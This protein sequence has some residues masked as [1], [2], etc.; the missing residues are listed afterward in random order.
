MS[1]DWNSRGI[2]QTCGGL[3]V[4]PL[5]V[6]SLVKVWVWFRLVIPETFSSFFKWV[7]MN[8]LPAAR[9]VGCQAGKFRCKSCD[10]ATGRYLQSDPIGLAGGGINTYAYVSDSPVNAYDPNGEFI[11][12]VGGVAIGGVIGGIVSYETG[13]S[14]WNGFVK[15][16]V[17]GGTVAAL[18]P[19]AA[20]A[21][22]GG[23]EGALIGGGITGGVSDAASQGVSIGLGYQH[24]FS[25]S[26]LAGS[27][28][29]GGLF[30]GG[31]SAFLNGGANT[32]LWSG[33]NQGALDA[34]QGAGTTIED[35]VIGGFLN[36][37]AN[38][39]NLPIPNSTWDW[40]SGYWL[41]VKYRG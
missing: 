19:W 5:N 4:F 15:G 33:F 34:A 41:Y 17:A 35:T 6:P 28:L 38:N 12:I 37:L 11:H 32:V 29:F 23:I 2:A 3:S 40:A 25:G 22:G 9:V 27:T 14:F 21:F 10:P 8:T 39:K 7:F 18:G 36:N 31:T 1:N 24:C 26:E 20:A 30:S 13:G 16:A